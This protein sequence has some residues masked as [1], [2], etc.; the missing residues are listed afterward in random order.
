[1]DFSSSSLPPLPT[2]LSSS[3]PLGSPSDARDEPRHSPGVTRIRFA[4]LRLHLALLAPS[5]ADIHPDQDREHQEREDRRPL[6]KETGHDQDEADVLRMTHVGIGAA[7][8]QLMPLLGRVEYPPGRGQ[9]DEPAADQ[10]ATEEVQRVQV[11]VALPSEQRLPEMS[12]VV[13]E[14]IQSGL[15]GCEQARKQVDRQRETVHLGK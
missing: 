9:D 13:G 7:G 12:R 1:M 5:K 8:G 4:K 3:P 14:K 11:W 10:P 2:P 15:A 6:E